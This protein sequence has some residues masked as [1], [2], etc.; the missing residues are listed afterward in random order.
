[1]KTDVML[2]FSRKKINL[3]TSIT[4]N[5]RFWKTELSGRKFMFIMT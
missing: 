2:L 4:L 1:M 5:K 3:K